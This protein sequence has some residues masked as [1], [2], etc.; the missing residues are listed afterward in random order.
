MKSQDQCSCCWAFSAVEAMEGFIKIKTGNLISLSEQQLVDCIQGCNIGSM[1]FAFNYIIE[2]HGIASET[3]YPYQ[4][5]ASTCKS[6]HMKL[7]AHINGFVKVPRN[8]EEQLLQAVVNQSVSVAVSLN[9]YFRFYKEG[10]FTGPCETN[11]NH[12]VTAIGYGTGKNGTKYWLIKNQWGGN[13]GEGG[14][15]RLLRQS[16]QPEGLC[17]IAMDPSYPI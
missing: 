8:S 13:W 12:A 4:G 11:L 16:G 17:G 2:N 3:N 10:I 9:N 6:D 5:V 14:F 15:M 7:S 1:D